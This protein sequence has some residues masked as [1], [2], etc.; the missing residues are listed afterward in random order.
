[1]TDQT[2]DTFA[3]L[4]QPALEL[5]NRWVRVKFGGETVADSKEP[6]LL[7]QYG[8]RMLPTYFFRLDEVRIDLLERGE[9]R[10]NK[11]FWTVRAGDKE[12]VRAAWAYIDPP[13]GLEATDG[14]LTFVWHK[15]DAWYEEEEEVFVHAR[16]P[17][18]R[19]DVMPSSRH[20]KVVVDGEVIA[21]SNRPH[22]LFETYLPTR[23]YLPREDVNTDYLQATDTMT[24]C[25]YK[26][27][28]E[29]WS[30]AV[31]DTVYSD[32]V[33][34]YPDPIPE[35]PKI[36]GLMCFYNEK[37]DLYVDGELQA[38]PQTPWS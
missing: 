16:D 2:P 29:Y 18:K 13:P 10:D 15:M 9:D 6:L 36:K 7:L 8:P 34:S 3:G 11:R 20:I 31:G 37:V 22:I 32:L 4:P 24:A 28:A 5:S 12:A 17:H 33:W 27:Q 14:Y 19:V 1:M 30:I 35:N 23:Y 38:R 21:E 25:P 26:G